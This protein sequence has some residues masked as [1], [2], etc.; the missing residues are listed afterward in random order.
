MV[1]YLRHQAYLTKGVFTAVRDDRTKERQAFYFEGGIQSYVKHLNIGKEVVSNNIFY[2]ER[3]VEYSM[4]EVAVQYNDSF[5]ELVKPFANN[6]LTPDGG[7]HLVGFRAAMTRVIN[8]YAR[9]NSLLKEKEDNLSGDD[10]RE[11]L[12]AII[13]VKLPDPQFE[14]QT[15]NKLET[16][17]F[18]AM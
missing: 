12:T 6:V 1:D 11:E 17:R 7:T 9:K 14:G 2:V 16:Q 13:L 8:D 4:V 5:T 15:K 10:I 18:V 3:Q